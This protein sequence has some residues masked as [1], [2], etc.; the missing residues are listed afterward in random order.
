MLWSC[1]IYPLRIRN[2]PVSELNPIIYKQVM[3]I[4]LPG[5]ER[6]DP[7]YLRVDRYPDPDPTRFETNK[8]MNQN[9]DPNTF[10]VQVQI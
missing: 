8:Y 6:L 5:T 10:R 4:Y 9:S 7:K 2:R 1:D 3:Y